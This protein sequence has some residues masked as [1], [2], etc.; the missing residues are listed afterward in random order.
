MYGC[1]GEEIIALDALSLEFRFRFGSELLE[2]VRESV[3]VGDELFVGDRSM[4]YD[5]DGKEIAEMCYG[6][7]QV[8]SLTGQYL[9]KIR[10]ADNDWGSVDKLCHV[11]GRLHF[12]NRKHDGYCIVVLTPEGQ[13]LQTFVLQ[14]TVPCSFPGMCR[15]RND[16]L[17]ISNEADAADL[18]AVQGI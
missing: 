9:H 5:D 1:G 15:F 8:F 14:V 6:R 4:K 13:R 11:S 17:L 2:D 7:L 12:I 18:I 10:S 3:V 16:L